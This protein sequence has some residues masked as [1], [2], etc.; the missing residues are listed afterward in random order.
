MKHPSAELLL[1]TE[2]KQDPV[3]PPVSHKKPFWLSHFFFVG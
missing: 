2:A 1:S 3:R